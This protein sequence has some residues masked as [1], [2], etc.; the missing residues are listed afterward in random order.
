M[1]P[2]QPRDAPAASGYIKRKCALRQPGDGLQT[3]NRIPDNAQ[4][5]VMACPL[6]GGNT[7][8]IGIFPV[9]GSVTRSGPFGPYGNIRWREFMSSLMKSILL[10]GVA[11]IALGGPGVA[12][13]GQAGSPCVAAVS[14]AQVITGPGQTAALRTEGNSTVAAMPTP[15]NQKIAAQ[16]T[17]QNSTVAALRTQ[18]N[19]TVAAMRTQENSTVAAM[20]TPENQKIAAQRTQQNS[21]VAAMPT[22]ENQKVA[23]QRTQENSTVAAMPTPENQ[24][25]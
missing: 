15:E 21:T 14:G 24:K 18:E 8:P 19:S 1:S 23:A 17:Q 4:R 5:L 22:P 11:A 12:F 9:A 13:A 10:A 25:V 16:R 2:E 6:R 20:P 3:T 7:G